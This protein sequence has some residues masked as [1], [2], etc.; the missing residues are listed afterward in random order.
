MATQVIFATGY[1]REIPFTINGEAFS[2]PKT[3]LYKYTFS[4]KYKGFGFLLFM[5]P[6]GPSFQCGWIQSK[7]I[8]R[9]LSGKTELPD[10]HIM[11]QQSIPLDAHQGKGGHGSFLGRR[12]LRL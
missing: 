7:Y 1:H 10:R 3:P 2:F 5:H 9:V 8:S 6:V 12:A 11:E 4:T